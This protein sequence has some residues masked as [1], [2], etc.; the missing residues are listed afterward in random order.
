MSVSNSLQVPGTYVGISAIRAQSGALP[1]RSI[2]IGQKLA[3]G[4]EASEQLFQIFSKEDAEQKAGIGSMLAEMA[5]YWFR[6]N[7]QTPI[8][9]IALDDAGAA[10]AATQ[11]VTFTGP[12]TAG[13]SVNLYINNELYQVEVTSGDSASDVAAA[14]DAF[15][16]QYPALPVTASNAAGVLTLTA[17]NG[18]TVGNTID[19]RVNKNEGEETPAG[20]T[21]V[22]AAGVS[23][24]TDPDIDDAIAA[25]PDEVFGAFVSPYNDVTN[26]AK[27][28][29]E[30]ERRF[31]K[32]VEL[33]GQV[34]QAIKG[35]TSDVID[36]ADNEN[37]PNQCVFDGGELNATP[38]YLTVSALAGVCALELEIDPAR[39]LKTLPLV[40]VDA[41]PATNRRNLNERQSLLLNGASIYDVE[42][43]TVKIG[44][45]ITTNLTNEVGSPTDA[46]K[47]ANVEF[48][49]SYLRQDIKG[50]VAQRF[51][52]HKLANN[53]TRFGAGQPIVT[54]NIFKGEMVARF[55]LW[56]EQGLVEDAS[57]FVKDII[58]ERE[59]QNV[60]PNKLNAILPPN[61][62]NAFLI[63]DIDIEFLS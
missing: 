8:Y 4:T 24:A 1:F 19:V 37:S 57:Q 39:P 38:H 63:A 58:V 7:N 21:A 51:P 30:A 3:A 44:R 49:A 52:R 53:G 25:I 41:E 46:Y 29:T 10:T 43:G 31:S 23:G 32:T 9:C 36:F 59:D 17:K 2:L 40:G 27:I 22:V 45:L 56:E 35:T 20:M 16:D 12:A 47:Q 28:V 60:N 15:L 33:E 26:T 50:I 54:P 48:I 62:V 14:V 18:G 55:G 13:G 61:F 5:D 6:N 34:F 11:T 42:A